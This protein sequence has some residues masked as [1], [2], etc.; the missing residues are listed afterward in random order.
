MDIG[1]ICADRFKVHNVEL[2]SNYF[3][4]TEMSYLKDLKT[5]LDKTK[6]KV[7]Q[8]NIELPPFN[9]LRLRKLA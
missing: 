5:R 7:V 1:Q 6:T 2:Q 3:P 4:S 9:M 8:I